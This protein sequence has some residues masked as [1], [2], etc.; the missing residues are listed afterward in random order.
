MMRTRRVGETAE[1]TGLLPTVAGRAQDTG[2]LFILGAAARGRTRAGAAEESG[3]TLIGVA[4]LPSKTRHHFA[5]AGVVA[6]VG[7]CRWRA[8]GSE[9]GEKQKQ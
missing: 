2:K 1:G 6:R 5:D 9:G 8:P 3:E 4:G 7:P